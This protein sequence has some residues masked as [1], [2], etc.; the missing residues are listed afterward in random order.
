MNT[1]LPIYNEDIMIYI[2]ITLLHNNGVLRDLLAC[3]TENVL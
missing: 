3:C 2:L 1:L